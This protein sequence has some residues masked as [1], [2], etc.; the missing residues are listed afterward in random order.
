MLGE[1]ALFVL[2]VDLVKDPAVLVRAYDDSR[3][4]TA[5]F[6]R[7]VLVRA[8]AELGADFDLDAFAHRAVWNAEQSRIEMH[9]QAQAPTTARVDGR[10]AVLHQRAARMEPTPG[11]WPG[12]VRY[13]A[14]QVDGQ[15]AQP[16]GSRD[17][18]DQGLR[19][20]VNRCAPN[21]LGR[22]HLDDPAQVHDGDPVGDLSHHRQVVGD[23]DECQPGLADQLAEQVR[24]LRLG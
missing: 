12:R 18:R 10:A 4:V 20:R 22:S 21:L 2:G 14:G 5:A 8:N 17:G 11:G 19:V 23:E 16:V 6:N 15:Q 3:G 24:H 7:N 1:G 13:V 9:L